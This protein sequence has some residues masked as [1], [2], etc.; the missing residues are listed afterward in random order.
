[1]NALFRLIRLTQKIAHRNTAAAA[2]V[3]LTLEQR[4]K[5]RLRVVLDDGREAGIFLERGEALRDGDCLWGADGLIVHVKAAAERLS[6]VTCADPLLLARACYHLGNR[7][8]ALQIEPRRL[9]YLHDRVLDD[10][11]RGLGLQVIIEDAPF[12]PEPG[13]YGSHA[14]GYGDRHD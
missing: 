11:V 4:A 9:R 2:S 1:L 10:L 3:T 12:E 14:H 8:V 7:H 6:T 13:V 5:R